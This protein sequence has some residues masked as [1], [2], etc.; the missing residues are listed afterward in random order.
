MS[1]N[2][3]HPYWMIVRDKQVTY[4]ISILFTHFSCPFDELIISGE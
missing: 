1:K 4:T 2:V 3:Y